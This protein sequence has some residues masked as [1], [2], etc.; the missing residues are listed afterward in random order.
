MIAFLKIERTKK[1]AHRRGSLH[2]SPQNTPD[3]AAVLE[4][5]K[6]TLQQSNT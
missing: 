5:K 1:N 2:S 6:G 3:N 4:Q